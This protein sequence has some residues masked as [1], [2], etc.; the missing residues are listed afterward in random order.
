[1]NVVEMNQAS[2]LADLGHQV[3]LITRRASPEAPDTVPIRPG[4][5]LRHVIGGPA[6][7]L[8]KSAQDAHLDEFRQHL[9]ELGAQ[10]SQV[11]SGGGR[12]AYDVVHSH[13]WMSG[14]AA[15]PLARSWGIPHV[16]SFHSVAALPGDPLHEGEPPE[17]PAR[18]GGEARCAQESDL[19][20]TISAHEA[21]T[22]VERC[23]ADP[24][25]VT[26]V[27]PGV[28][29]EL[30]RP[31]AAGQDPLSWNAG[32][33]TPVTVGDHGYVFFAAR[34]QPLKGADLAIAS[35]ASLPISE[36]PHLVIAGEVSVDF[37]DYQA[38]L[39]ALVQ[40]L[41]MSEYVTF[42]GPQDRNVLAA[43]LRGAR[44][45]LVPSHS[46]TF[47]LIALEAS[48]SGVPVLAMAAGGL[49]E[50]VVDGESGLL[51]W[52]RDPADWGAALQ[53]LLCP[54]VH[55]RAGQV[56]RIHSRRFVWADVAHRLARIY[57][58][59]MSDGWRP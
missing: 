55:L 45:V 2:A 38:E 53:R 50:A 16:Q 4:V 7:P 36:R 57:G 10:L 44:V 12:P 52:T 6:T 54:G 49:R 31:L 8:A 21:R 56:G 30:F 34:L 25:R 3:D 14:V 42:L 17:S 40:D 22:V 58:R 48:A 5:T 27:P 26:I 33:T 9:G 24:N 13:H 32:L 11:L 43:M 46:E 29:G 47:G 39:V 41:D 28:D 59:L 51:M 19:I 35:V 37:A 15:L 18:V 20:V 1:M 23:G